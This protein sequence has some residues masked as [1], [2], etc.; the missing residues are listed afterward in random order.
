MEKLKSLRKDISETDK[1]IHNATESYT[2]EEEK[3]QNQ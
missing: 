2:N 1:N 3:R